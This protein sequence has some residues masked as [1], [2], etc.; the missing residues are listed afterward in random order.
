MSIKDQKNLMAPF[1]MTCFFSP[2]VT[3][4]Q[5]VSL[6]AKLSNTLLWRCNCWGAGGGVSAW[7]RFAS[8]ATW[9]RWDCGADTGL[10]LP[11]E[12]PGLSQGTRVSP[13]SP[14]HAA[15]S[16]PSPAPHKPRT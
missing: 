12:E 11:R 13:R 1:L 5:L 2:I 16:Q 9:G 14:S 7:R 6:F 15:S 4:F 3:Y 8:G 10:L